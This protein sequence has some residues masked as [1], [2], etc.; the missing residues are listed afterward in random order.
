MSDRSTVSAARYLPQVIVATLL[1][2]VVPVAVVWELRARGV[3]TS[4]WVCLPLAVALSLA[5]SALGSAYW[6][7]RRGS[8]DIMFSELLLWGWLRRLRI[9]RQLARATQLLGPGDRA[10]AAGG[11]KLS[12]ERSRQLLGQ[13]VAALE[14]QDAYT[15]R[16]SR[17]VARNA[18]TT[19]R[20]M[21]LPDEEVTTIRAAA[22][23]HDVGKLHVPRDLLNKP[24]TLTDAE[25]EVVRH[26]AEEGAAMVECLGNPELTAI[27]RHHHERMDGTG[28]PAG[29]AAEEI[30]I[31]ARIVAVVDTFDAII[32]SRPY[33][34]AAPHKRAINVLV[35]ETGTHFDENVVHAF[36]S[37]YS[38]NR[39]LAIWAALAAIPESAFARQRVRRGVR[40]PTSPAQRTA[41][42][43][44][45]VMIAAAALAAPIGVKHHQPPPPVSPAAA[46]APIAAVKHVTRRSAPLAKP[47]TVRSVTCQAYN[48]Q[49]CSSLSGATF[50]GSSSGSG[51]GASATLPFTGL[52]AA[53][54]ALIAGALVALGV[55]VR[56]LSQV[57]GGSNGVRE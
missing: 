57:V 2:A 29:L 55:A 25:S 19:A 21:G 35:Q 37:S 56:R 54:L 20:R 41:T 51:G 17:R 34:P 47:Q 8:G 28:Y 36:L 31:G 26:H 24:S 43:A 27:V 6:K 23:V 22:A 40:R 32:S 39:A 11:G 46:A 30:P 9:E 4:S 13:L 10:E 5:G 48:P 50:G 49:L 45:F 1:V 52:D 7:R 38:G 18:E 53:V 14:A 16:H 12:V 15:F 44:A 3:V 42:V 33:R